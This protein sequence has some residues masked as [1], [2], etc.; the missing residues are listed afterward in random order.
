MSNENLK[1]VNYHKKAE[2]RKE[3]QLTINKIQK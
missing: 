2:K 3:K 1:Q